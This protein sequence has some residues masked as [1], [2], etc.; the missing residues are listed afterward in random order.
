[1]SRADRGK[2]DID[3]SDEID[4]NLLVRKVRAFFSKIFSF[5]EIIFYLI[6]RK[7]IF[8]LILTLLG[9]AI[10]YSIHSI[11]RPYYGYS[12]TVLLSEIRNDFV[13]NLIGNLSLLV[14]EKNYSEV[15][16][17]L[18][19]ELEAAKQIKSIGYSNLDE[20]RIPE[21]SVVVGAPFLISVELYDKS[22]PAQIEKGIVQYLENNRYLMMQKRIKKEHLESIVQKLKRDIASIDSTKVNSAQPKGP[23]NGFVYG[24]PVDPANLYRESVAMFERQASLESSLKR[25]EIFDVIVHFAPRKGPTGPN[26]RKYMA[27]GALAFFFLGLFY[28]IINERKRQKKLKMNS[29]VSS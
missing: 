12:M 3:L 9:T 22:I 25:L 24:A 26:Q 1:M 14:N 27:A 20:S 18:N 17:Q 10:A 4:L 6:L 7:W 19:I 15:S 13:R 16:R 2:P 8:F 29:S 28:Q 23:V 11:R 21:D 5:F